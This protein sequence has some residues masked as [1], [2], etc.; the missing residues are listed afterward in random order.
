MRSD[1]LLN[2]PRTPIKPKTLKK[3]KPMGA[4]AIPSDEVLTAKSG[5][6][7]PRQKIL[8]RNNIRPLQLVDIIMPL[9]AEFDTSMDVRKSAIQ[10]IIKK[11]RKNQLVLSQPH[12]PISRRYIGHELDFTFLNRFRDGLYKRWI[13]S[14]YSTPVLEMVNNYKVGE[15]FQENVIL[16]EAPKKLELRSLRLAYRITPPDDIDLRLSIWPDGTELG[17][18]DISMDGA[19]FYHDPRWYFPKKSTMSLQLKSGDVIIILNAQVVR[20]AKVIDRYGGKRAVTCVEFYNISAENRI[21]FQQLIS[22]IYRH[23]LTRRAGSR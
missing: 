4:V 17:L 6:K 1:E 15:S 16:I 18:M 22:G 19:R 23:L 2:T 5:K 14:G 3:P 20:Q 21:R 7:L 11:K 8:L 10:D 13:R 12:P 9:Q